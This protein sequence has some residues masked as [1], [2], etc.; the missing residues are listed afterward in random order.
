[1]TDIPRDDGSAIVL[2]WPDSVYDLQEVLRAFPHAV[3]IVGGAVRDAY[4]RH[5]IKDLDLATDG[6]GIKL[7]R[8]IANALKG[9]FYPLDPTRDVGRAILDTAEGRLVVDAA[10]FRGG[11]LEA[12]LAE[13]DFT[14]NALAVD[15]RSDLNVVYDPLGG[16]DDLR[17]KRL[18]LCMPSALASDPIRS[19][20]AIRQSVQF[21]LRLDADLLTALRGLHNPLATVSPERVRDEFFKLLSL[22]RP[23]SALRILKSFDLLPEFRPV[24]DRIL[25][26][27]DHLCGIW[28][29]ISPERSDDM[30]AQFAYGMLAIQFGGLRASLQQALAQTYGAERSHRTLLVF[31]ALLLEHDP[32]T[33]AALCARLRLSNAESERVRL[34]VQAARQVPFVQD[35][36]LAIY[37]Y[38]RNAGDAG[39]DGV[40]LALS[41]ALAEALQIDQTAWLKQLDHA[42][43]LLEAYLL[44][45]ETAV[46]PPP[47][48]DGTTLIRELKLRPGPRWLQHVVIW[49]E[50]KM[51]QRE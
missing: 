21:G 39:V 38:W 30:V 1:M 27:V 47:L 32:D 35:E 37:H 29:V 43:H 4:L 10:Q 5:P 49:N 22:P 20:R 14:L 33:C 6:S 50:A 18:R 41:D 34:A 15:L 23:A 8:V 40:L 28:N 17:A 51:V 31:S 7:A 44:Y 9:N 2:A 19:L 3:Y 12:D 46:D 24:N 13:R 26:T 42:R 25:R 11:T 48:I 45:R 36:P 16:L